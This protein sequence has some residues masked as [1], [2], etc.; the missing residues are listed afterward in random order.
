MEKTLR[1]LVADDHPLIRHGLRQVLEGARFSV[2]GEAEDG[3]RAVELAHELRPD[4]VVMDLHMP[5]ADGL[6]ATRLI[7]A[8]EAAPQVLVVSAMDSEQLVFG[9]L[10]AGA[11]GYVLK[12]DASRL[13][14]TAVAALA[15]GETFFS[16]RISEL[17]L[18]GF[19]KPGEMPAGSAAAGRL[20]AREREIVALLAS[21]R[22]GKEAATTLG[23]SPK[24]VEAHRTNIMR[25][26]DLHSVA[27]LVLYAVRTGIVS[28]G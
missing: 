9:V 24:T 20:S 26:L 19:L 18:H 17:V 28:A 8:L 10:E 4:V 27:E 12:S 1:I 7:R 2:C 21:G 22:T 16:G 5:G 11:R 15:A 23:I 6:E 25:K 13:I 14:P 3:L